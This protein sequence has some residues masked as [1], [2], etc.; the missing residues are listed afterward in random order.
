V[1][2][3]HISNDADRT[4]RAVSNIQSFFLV[5]HIFSVI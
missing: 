5:E 3:G 4:L 2:V 1:T